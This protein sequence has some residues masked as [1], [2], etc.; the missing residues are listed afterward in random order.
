MPTRF[1]TRGGWTLVELAA[2]L[3][4]ASM[5]LSIG[6]V[7]ASEFRG[8]AQTMQD[9]DNLAR[10]GA[11]GA[12]YR[13]DHRNWLV[14]S[15]GTSGRELLND[16]RAMVDLALEVNGLATQPFDWASPLMPYLTDDPDDIPVRRDERFA[17]TNGTRIPDFESPAFDPNDPDLSPAG[18]FAVFADPKQE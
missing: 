6:A 16:V 11:A 8:D 2:T 7:T 14:G 9:Q 5:L 1:S 18:P 10:I 4:V 15:P 12:H 13:A 3:C 17:L